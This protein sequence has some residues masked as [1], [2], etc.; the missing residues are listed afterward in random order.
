MPLKGLERSGTF[1]VTF[2]QR[3]EQSRVMAGE[4]LVDVGLLVTGSLPTQNIRIFIRIY[5]IAYCNIAYCKYVLD[6]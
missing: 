2:E 1:N 4:D 6:I 3:T 5:N